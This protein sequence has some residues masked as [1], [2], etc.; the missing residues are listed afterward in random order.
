MPSYLIEA[1][2]AAE[3]GRLEEARRRARRAAQ[4][5]EEVR[6]VRTTFVP[7]DETCFHLF[8]APSSEALV[9]AVR[10]AELDHLRIVE[11]VETAGSTAN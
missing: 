9:E 7:R 3:P 2:L 11:A 5:G 1:Y 10:L 4:L 6:Y 8:E